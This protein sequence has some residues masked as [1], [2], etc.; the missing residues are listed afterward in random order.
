MSP[1]SAHSGLAADAEL[2]TTPSF[3]SVPSRPLSQLHYTNKHLQHFVV[4]NHND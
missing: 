1:A 2:N 3:V 4:S